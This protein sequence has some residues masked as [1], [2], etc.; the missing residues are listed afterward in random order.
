MEV[1][2]GITGTSA[3]SGVEQRPTLC[4]DEA[5]ESAARPRAASAP[6]EEVAPEAVL[7]TAPAE[8]PCTLGSENESVKDVVKEVAA[9]AEHEEAAVS[10]AHE[11]KD[12]TVEQVAVHEDAVSSSP[13]STTFP[14]P[15]PWAPNVEQPKKRR[16][17]TQKQRQEVYGLF[18]SGSVSSSSVLRVCFPAP[19]VTQPAPIVSSK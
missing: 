19:Q 1:K 12:G 13:D 16:R 7:G 11:E 3:P 9:V 15:R 5:E 6:V 8:V 4:P 14:A 17:M 10:A 18:G 2:A